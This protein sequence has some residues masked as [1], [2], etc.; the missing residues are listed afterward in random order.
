MPITAR[1]IPGTNSYQG[2]LKYQGA[3]HTCR[4]RHHSIQGARLCLDL[5]DQARILAAV[6][7]AQHEATALVK[8]TAVRH[9]MMHFRSCVTAQQEG[10]TADAHNADGAYHAVASLLGELLQMPTGD[11]LDFVHTLA[12]A[13]EETL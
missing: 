2:V 3:E 6:A 1:N 4:H 10:R 13:N 7:R 8:E 11:V 9:A 5:H 12:A